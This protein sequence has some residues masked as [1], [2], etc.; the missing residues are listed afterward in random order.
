M[1]CL[2]HLCSHFHY[3]NVIESNLFP[4]ESVRVGRVDLRVLL[5]TRGRGRVACE[6][7]TFNLAMKFTIQMHYLAMLFTVHV[8][9]SAI[10]YSICV[11]NFITQS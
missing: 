5:R 2:R 7:N 10:L 9:L 4:D 1:F 8:V 3:P 6:G 11:V